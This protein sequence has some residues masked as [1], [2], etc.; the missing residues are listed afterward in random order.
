MTQ[1]QRTS[2][3]MTTSGKLGSLASFLSSPA[4]LLDLSS[5]MATPLSSGELKRVDR[6]REVVATLHQKGIDFRQFVFSSG[7]EE[8]NVIP[9]P[10]GSTNLA[11][12]LEMVLNANPTTV[13]VVS[14]GEPD[15]ADKAMAVARRFK[16]KGIQINVLYCGDPGSPGEAFMQQLAQ[17]T[18]GR[19]ET[20]DLNIEPAQLTGQAMLMLGDGSPESKTIIL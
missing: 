19:Q 11:G 17:A 9:E 12:G 1:L 14:D 3:L 20:V 2:N 6:V 8:T 15:N 5:S 18:G 13:T 7:C 10:Y 16:D 4:L